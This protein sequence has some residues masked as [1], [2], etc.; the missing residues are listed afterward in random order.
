M[1]VNSASR[2]YNDFGRYIQPYLDHFGLPYR[3]HDLGSS[4]LPPDVDRYALIVVGHGELDLTGSYLGRPGQQRLVAAVCDGSGLVNFDSVLATP[5]G[6]ARYSYVQ[7]LFGFVYEGD[8]PGAVTSI[9]IQRGGLAAAIT[10]RHACGEVISLFS[11]MS[12]QRLTPPAGADILATGEGYPFLVA[13]IC[14]NGRVV[15]WGSYAWTDTS[16]RGPLFG[17]DDLVWR[18]FAWA[19][20]KP[21][22]MRGMPPFVTMRVDDVS[23]WGLK[24]GPS[25]LWWVRTACQYGF[26]PW[27]GLFIGELSRQGVDELKGYITTHQATASVHA[28]TWH[29]FFYFDHWNRKPFPDGVLADHF[30]Q[31][32]EWYGRHGDFP[33]SKVVLGHFYELGVNALDGLA[34][35]RV[36]F[37]G[38]AMDIGAPYDPPDGTPWLVAGPYRLHEE[39]RP[40]NENRRPLHYADFLPVPTS[41]SHDR[42]F[43]N[44]LTEIRDNAGYEW[45][46]DNDVPRTIERGV[47]QLRRA[48][49]SMVLAT[50]F[51]HESDYVQHIRPDTWEAALAGVTAG[52]ASYDPVY[53]TLDEACRYL[54]AL[55][56]SHIETAEWDPQKRRLKIALT[57]RADVPTQ[58]ALFLDEELRPLCVEVPAFEGQTTMEYAL[59]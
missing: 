23:G 57:G 38:T 36:E 31:A 17:L 33:R 5:S 37:L 24:T 4:P 58:M 19:A 28:F 13:T 43:F 40:A 11:A 48:L 56:T 25:P 2:L 20:R 12:L 3:R 14:G 59:E 18:A 15:Q 41:L 34:R 35:S 39:P 46:P 21:F 29:S 1:V 53:I 27:L 54:R 16:V 7:E 49:D 32:K 50:L 26:R 45:A 10:D 44:V 47:T 55:H 8:P 30:A 52:I 51:T 42:K 6:Q 22:L 9:Q